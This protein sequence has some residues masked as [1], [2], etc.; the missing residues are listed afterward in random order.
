MKYNI[1]FQFDIFIFCT[2]I[3]LYKTECLLFDVP[4]VD[5]FTSNIW[6]SRVN[7]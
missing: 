4:D 2:I 5:N 1:Q 7:L 6:I 3:M